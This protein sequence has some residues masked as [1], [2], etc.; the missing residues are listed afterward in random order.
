VKELVCFLNIIN[1]LSRDDR[2]NEAHGRGRQR[3]VLDEALNGWT[4]T[5]I[6]ANNRQGSEGMDG[7]GKGKA[8]G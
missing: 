3:N 7:I 8:Q 4:H 2:R 1:L 5:C 6:H